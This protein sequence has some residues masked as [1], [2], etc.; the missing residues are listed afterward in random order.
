MG[1]FV[2]KI[3]VD[4]E[5]EKQKLLNESLY[6]HNRANINTDLCNTLAH[7]YTFPDIIEVAEKSSAFPV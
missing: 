7:L 4:T 1:N 6:I 2:I 5:E 3:I